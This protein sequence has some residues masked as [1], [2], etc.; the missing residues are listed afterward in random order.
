MQGLVSGLPGIRTA[1][2]SPPQYP[3]PSYALATRVQTALQ[4]DLLSWKAQQLHGPPTPPPPPTLLSFTPAPTYTLGR[5]QTSQPTGP[6]LA[7]LRAPLALESPSESP[8]APVFFTPAVASAPRGGLATYHGPGQV[9]LWPVI[10][11]RSPLHAHFTVRE[12]ACLLE[13][14]TIAALG[15]NDEREGKKNK[16]A[17][18]TTSNPGVWVRHRRRSRHH[19]EGEE[20]SEDDVEERKIA[21]LGVHLRRHVTG[22]G[23]AI[24]YA[25]PVSGP[26][27]ANPWGRIVACGLS[28]KG[29]TSVREEEGG[30]DGRLSRDAGDDEVAM[31][32]LADA[33]AREFARR[34]EMRHEGGDGSPGGGDHD[35]I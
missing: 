5:R 13:K 24:N 2:P 14:T 15:G 35:L 26:E 27:A 12:Y 25:T 23:V 34:L 3:Y 16:I 29:V 20:E 18:F 10:D 31:R 1:L 7:R 6:E 33:W 30:G 4:Q 28:D 19:N 21:A 11:L 8:S 22:L 17:G 32:R 9:V